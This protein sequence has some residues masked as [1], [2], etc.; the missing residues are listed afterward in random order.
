MIRVGVTGGIGSGKSTVCRVL[1]ALGYPVF[2]ADWEARVITNTDKEV[3]EQI[4]HLLGE[5]AYN[6]GV[7]NRPFVAE[8]VFANT[9]LLAGLNAIVHPAVERHFEQ[10]CQQHSL[11]KLV[12]EE[13]AVLFESGGHKKMDY[14]V[15]VVADVEQR[16]QRVTKRDNVTKQMVLDRM[17][18]QL[19][20]DELM[21]RS[22]FV[23][24]N[25]DTDMILPQVFTL[26][27]NLLASNQLQ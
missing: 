16:L 25:N 2:H 17:N 27:D 23:V 3:V 1:T 9:T 26:L 5:Q 12:F 22:N 11:H 7:L 4:T 24:R 21:A 10:W 15:A 18:N 8:K 20:A 13:A 19:S 6:G 14:V